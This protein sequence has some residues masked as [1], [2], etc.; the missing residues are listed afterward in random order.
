MATLDTSPNILKRISLI[1][2]KDFTQF[3]KEFHPIFKQILR[4]FKENFM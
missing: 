1:L 3:P 2:K 4:N